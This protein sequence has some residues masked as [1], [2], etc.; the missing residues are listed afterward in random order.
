MLEFISQ[1]AKE[2]GAEEFIV[3]LSKGYNQQVGTWFTN[4]VQLSGG[5]WQKLGIARLFM[6]GGDVFILDEPTASLDPIAEYNLFNKFIETKRDK[7]VLLI[8]HRFIN[9]RLSDDIIVMKN[10]EIKERGNH[11]EEKRNI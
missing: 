2:A 5:E 4:G 1:V 6:K 8:T 11:N 10:G 3:K 9:A 7:L